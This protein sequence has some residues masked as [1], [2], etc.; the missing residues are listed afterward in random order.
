[1]RKP[2]TMRFNPDVLMAAKG[3]AVGDARSLTNDIE[4]LK[5]LDMDARKIAF[6]P[7]N[8]DFIPRLTDRDNGITYTA[9]ERWHQLV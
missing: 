5:A 4:V 2:V 6:I 3:K 8:R 9:A 1:M 7:I